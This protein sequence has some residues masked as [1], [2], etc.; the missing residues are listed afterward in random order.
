MYDKQCFHCRLAKTSYLKMIDIWLIFC[1]LIPF[2]EVILHTIMDSMRFNSMDI[3][4]QAP[5]IMVNEI[6]INNFT[7]QTLLDSKTK[8][9]ILQIITK[10]GLPLIFVIFSIIFF[11]SGIYLKY[12]AEWYFDFYHCIKI[13]MLWL[14]Q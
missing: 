7:G 6:K 10:Y 1:L 14:T 9:Q 13:Y 8:L 12:F 11:S 3:T 2:V 4:P 5:T